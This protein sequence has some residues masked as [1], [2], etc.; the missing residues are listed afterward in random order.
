MIYF[1]NSA[2][3]WPK[4]DR[5]YRGVYEYM[6][7]Y[8]ANPGRSGHAMAR[9]SSDII[10]SCRELICEFIGGIDSTKVVFTKNATEALNIV[11]KGVMRGKGHAICTSM[12]H[13]SV[14]RPLDKL[15]KNGVKF[16]IVWGDSNGYVT[17]ED[18]EKKITP[19]TKLVIVNHVSNVCGTIQDISSIG[20]IA[21]KHGALFAVDGAQSG[22]V[23]DFDMSNIDFLCLAGHKGLYGPMGTGVLCINCDYPLD[24]LFEGGTGSYS[25]HLSQPEELPDRFESGTLNAVGIAGLLE[26]IKFLRVVGTNSIL[27]HERHLT[28]YFINGLMSIPNTAIY[29]STDISKRTGVVAFNRKDKDC[30]ELARI[31]NDKY[32]IACRAGYHCAY[33]AHQTIGS[34]DCGAVRFSFGKFNTKD[35]VSRA[36]FA[37]AHA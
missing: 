36:L 26:G 12:E 37:I 24:T 15:R 32:N 10:Y 6:R 27:E 23:L 4:P 11:I 25:S 2:T 7:K 9:A 16:D 13:N 8:A 35:E 17:P 19:E 33:T 3:T 20:K 28:S 29:G 31:L 5:V 34:G 21:H 30:V 14:L 22:G 1:D 18:I